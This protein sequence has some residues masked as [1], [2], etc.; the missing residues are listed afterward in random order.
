ML[1][2][3]EECKNELNEGKIIEELVGYARAYL[4]DEYNLELLVPIEINRRLS[5]SVGR[6]IYQPRLRKPVKIEISKKHIILSIMNDT[7]VDVF[8]TLKHELIHYALFV[9]ELPHR[10]S[11]HQFIKECTRQN[12]SLRHDGPQLKHV[13]QCNN[14]HRITRN[15]KFDVRKYRCGCGEKLSYINQEIL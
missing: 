9:K 5:R 7:F 2:K 11:D 4:S 10:D 15:N 6:F 12:V 1:K 3:Y 13:Y 8:D 14:G